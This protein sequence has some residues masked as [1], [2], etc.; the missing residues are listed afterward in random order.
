MVKRGSM[1]PPIDALLKLSDATMPSIIPVPNFSGYFDA[2]FV[3][4]RR[5]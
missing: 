5:R 2:F 3:Y 4:D 1:A